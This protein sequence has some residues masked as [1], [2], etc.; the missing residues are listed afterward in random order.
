[1]RKKLNM[2]C[3]QTHL[4][5]SASPELNNKQKHDGLLMYSHCFPDGN[6]AAV[7]NDRKVQFICS[8]FF[9]QGF[10]RF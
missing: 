8:L 5:D 4:L 9:F 1:M 10:K 2:L 7:T 6:V 3:L